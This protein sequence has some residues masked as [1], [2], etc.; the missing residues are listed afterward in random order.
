[1]SETWEPA[2]RELVPGAEEVYTSERHGKTWYVALVNDG[3]HRYVLGLLVQYGREAYWPLVHASVA[4]EKVFSMAD[5]VVEG[6]RGEVG[7]R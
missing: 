1:M 2:D 6:R 4:P 7:K 5:R 3:L